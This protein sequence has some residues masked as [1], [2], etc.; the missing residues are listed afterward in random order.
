MGGVEGGGG[1]AGAGHHLPALEAWRAAG[2]GTPTCLSPGRGRRPLVA[3]LRASG[4]GGRA[5]GGAL[6]GRPRSAAPSSRAPAPRPRHVER[7]SHAFT[8][9]QE[10]KETGTRKPNFAP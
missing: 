8:V 1:C 7:T 4:C 2:G 6:K 5:V 3:G 10:V 9:T